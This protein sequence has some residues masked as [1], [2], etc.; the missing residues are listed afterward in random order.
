L[1]VSEQR[2][3]LETEFDFVLVGLFDEVERVHAAPVALRLP[4]GPQRP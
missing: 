3:F 4:A 1:S 2:Q